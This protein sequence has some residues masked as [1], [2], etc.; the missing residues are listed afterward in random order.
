MYPRKWSRRAWAV[1][2][3]IGLATLVTMDYSAGPFVLLGQ[4]TGLGLM[5][6]FLAGTFNLF[7]RGVGAAVA[8]VRG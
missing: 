1:A 3:L 7:G 5:V 2:V 6:L 8:R 4:L